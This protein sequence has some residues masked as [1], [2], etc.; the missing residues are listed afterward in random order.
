MTAGVG[1]AGLRV[2][3]VTWNSARVLP[4]LLSSIPD[5]VV[6]LDAP[7]EVVVVDN[8]SSDETVQLV[9]SRPEIRLVGSGCNAGYAAGVNLGLADLPAGWDVAVLNPDLRLDAGCLTALVRQVHQSAGRTGIAVPVQRDGR[10]HRLSTLRREPTVLRAL[11]EALL[12][13]HRAGRWPALGEL[14]VD[15]GAYRT[16][17]TA[18]WASGSALVISGDCLA[19]VGPWDESF[20]LYSEETEWMLRARD[21][22]WQVRLVPDATCV[23]LLGDSHTSPRLFALMTINRWHLYR[24]RNGRVRGRVLWSAL[25]IGLALR[26]PRD[27]PSRLALRAMLT[28]ERWAGRTFPAWRSGAAPRAA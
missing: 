9:T 27:A 3:V 21:L 13:G 19:R 17:T 6:G 20:F 18:D 23:H 7:F 14:V 2:V 15:E 28:P 11:G 4:G 25:M 1:P 12:G 16:T 10:G 22:D 26:A 8:D 5:A 24:R